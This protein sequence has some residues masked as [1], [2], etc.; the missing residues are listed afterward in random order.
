[1]P[2][3]SGTRPTRSGGQDLWPKWMWIAV[4]VLVI[5]VVAGLWW[6]IFSDSGPATP[7]ATPTPTMKAIYS[8]PTQMP[9]V[10][11]T[12]VLTPTET[13]AL[14]TLII[15]TFTPTVEGVTTPTAEAS[16][17]DA[18]GLGVGVKAKVTGTGGSGLNMRA[19]AGTG[20]ARVKTLGDNTVVEIIGGPKEANGFT[21]WQVRDETGTTGWVASKYLT[22]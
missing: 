11:K 14:P 15:P 2:L 10:Q 22:Q 7:T 4:P 3:D 16:T 20:H 12:L 21:W 9:P 19:G 13:V 6:A 18:S 17:G 1:M 5:V 8:P